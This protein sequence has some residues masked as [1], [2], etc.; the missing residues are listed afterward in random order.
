MTVSGTME[1]EVGWFLII[2]LNVDIYG[3]LEYNQRF[4]KI[5]NDYENL[6]FEFIR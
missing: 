4:L 2:L 5:W 1:E 3:V 6:K